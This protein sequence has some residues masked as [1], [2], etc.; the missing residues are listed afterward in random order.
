M[1]ENMIEKR[2]KYSIPTP[3]KI[4]NEFKKRLSTTTLPKSCETAD[5]WTVTVLGIFNQIGRS[6]GYRPR[7]EYLRLDQSWE[8]RHTDI[9]VIVL[10]LEHD[11]TDDVNEILD[12]E[13][14]KLIDVK[15]ILKVL[16]FYPIVPITMLESGESTIPD[17]QEKIRSAKIK[18]S[19]ERYLV[20]TGTYFSQKGIV[21]FSACVFDVEGKGED[22]GDFQIT[23]KKIKSKA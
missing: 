23:Y 4:F 20:I 18:Y 21:F 14:Q 13:L 17:I 8:I 7:K 6:F 9:S 3:Q 16:I 2:Y 11:N 10:A 12:D 5:S 19:D 1:V 22:L 15:A